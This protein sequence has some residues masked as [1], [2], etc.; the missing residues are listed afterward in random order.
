M[1]KWLKLSSIILLIPLLGKSILKCREKR[2]LRKRVFEDRTEDFESTARNIANS[3]SK[4]KA[5]YKELIIKIHPDKFLD[6][7]T[8]LIATELS[9]R[10]TKSK[11]NF[12]ELVK[13]KTEVEMFLE[14]TM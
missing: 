9:S 4:S 12:D 10:I 14:K 7:E 13:L 11:R 3:I 2:K 1:N 5:L 8:K 6:K